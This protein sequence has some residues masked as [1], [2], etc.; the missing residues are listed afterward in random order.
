[1]HESGV[2]NAV[3]AVVP[4]RAVKTLVA[5]AAN[6]LIA[7]V[8]DRVMCLVSAGCE[9]SGNLRLQN[10]ALDSSR[11]SMLGVVSMLV[12]GETSLAK[13]EVFAGV[14]MDEVALR[15]LRHAGVACTDVLVQEIMQHRHNSLS[16]DDWRR[17]CGRL[18]ARL[19]GLGLG[20]NALSG[21][22]DERTVLDEPLD[23]P[24]IGALARLALVNTFL[25]EIKV[26]I[27]AS[28]AMVMSPRD[29]LV[30]DVAAYSVRAR[31]AR[32][33][34]PA[35]RALSAEQARP[36]GRESPELTAVAEHASPV[37]AAAQGVNR[38]LKHVQIAS[39]LLV[40][41]LHC[42]RSLIEA[43]G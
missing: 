2:D 30:T 40:L 20:R 31:R 38:S 9:T 22:I 36:Q 4:V 11:E 29:G 8:T 27:V 34:A 19:W 28:R 14:A 39:D 35:Q 43:H 3:I 13:V 12:L 32:R 16:L 6:G 25:A 37:H 42:L 10:G 24:V 17:W 33:R 15:Q 26:S 1:V 41:F 21:A 5:N 18:L 23:Q 7:A